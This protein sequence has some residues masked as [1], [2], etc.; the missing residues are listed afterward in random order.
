MSASLVA[1]PKLTYNGLSR[2]VH[3][4]PRASDNGCPEDLRWG[5]SGNPPLFVRRYT[6]GRGANVRSPS[7]AMSVEFIG[8]FAQGKLAVHEDAFKQSVGSREPPEF[9]KAFDHDAGGG[10]GRSIICG[11]PA[12]PLVAGA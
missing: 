12:C 6:F 8:R 5:G 3:P 4:V 10:G 9:S 1:C 2:M 7:R 11:L